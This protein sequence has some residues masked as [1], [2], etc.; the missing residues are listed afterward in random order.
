MA[1]PYGATKEL[2]KS[3]K[4]LSGRCN[5]QQPHPHQRAD[6][7]WYAVLRVNLITSTSASIS[8]LPLQPDQKK[9]SYCS[10]C[11]IGAVNKNSNLPLI[12]SMKIIEP[13]FFF[14]KYILWMNFMKKSLGCHK[15]VNSG[16]WN[17]RYIFEAAIQMSVYCFS[18][19]SRQA[20]SL[21]SQLSERKKNLTSSE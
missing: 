8:L 21:A 2:L 13:N 12:P 4:L 15:R 7:G 16:W 1:R 10:Q 19:D 17:N 11:H 3:T 5:R 6:P 14:S 9:S 20:R 18:M